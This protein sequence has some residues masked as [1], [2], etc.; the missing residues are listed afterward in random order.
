MIEKI[1]EQDEVL[2]NKFFDGEELTIAELREGIRKGTLS[3]ELVPVLCGSALKNKGVQ[4]MLD[5]VVEY[6]PS[7]L[8]VPPIKALVPG[9]EDQFVERP[10][11][12][13]APFVHLRS[14]L[15]LILLLENY[16]FPSIFWC[17]KIRFIY[18]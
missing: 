4:S 6:L 16:L 17:S 18:L 12:D 9:T 1:V 11:S 7:P 10:P 3:G 14:K 8:D 13:E 2:M 15:L 5:A